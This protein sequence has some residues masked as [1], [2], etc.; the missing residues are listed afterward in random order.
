MKL[1]R[2][3]S[4]NRPRF[5]KAAGILLI[6]IILLGTSWALTGY[7]LQKNLVTTYQKLNSV[8]VKDRKGEE[9]F[10]LPNEKGDW[11]RFIDEVP[12]R[13]KELLLI[14]EDR[15]FY[16]HPGFNPVSI[17]KYGLSHLGLGRRMASSTI[18]QQ[19][20]KILLY[21]ELDR[22]VKNKIIELV[23][24]VSLELYKTKEEIL[25]MYVNSISFGNQATGIGEASRLYFNLPPDLL[26]DGQILQLLVTINNPTNNH[27]AKL[28]N[29][30]K[31]IALGKW[32]NLNPDELVILDSLTIK[33]NMRHYSR[34][35][36]AFFEVSSLI[37]ETISDKELTIDLLLNERLRDIVKR[38]LDDLRW[39]N[40]RNAAV[41]VIK[42]PEN[43]LLALIGSPDPQSSRDGYK[44][45][46]VS[47]PRPIGSTI[48]PFIYLKAFEKGLRPYTLVD[49]REYKYMTAIGLPLYPKN[50]DWKYR[51]EVD[52]HYALSNSLN[53][54]AVK[55]LEYVGLEDF[56]SFLEKNLG[57]KPI[58]PWESYQLGIALGGLDMSLLDL[59]KYFTIFPNNGI[60]RELSTHS[61][62]INTPDK[63][64][65]QPQ[66]IELIN[67][68]LQDRQTGMEQ[69]GMKSLLN[70]FQNNYAL[71]TGTSRDYRDSWVIGYTTDFLVGVWVGNSDNSPMDEVSGQVGAGL[72][73]SEIMGVL[74]N[75]GYNHKTPFTYKH[76]RE[77]Y[78][79]NTI[80][81][82]LSD[83]AY[84]QT[85]NI[86]KEKDSTLILSP[87]QDDTFLLEKNTRIILRAKEEVNWFINGKM[88]GNGQELTYTPVES[89][90]LQIHAQTREG[91]EEKIIVQILN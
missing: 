44:I 81:Y 28:R 8:A 68:I 1:S 45:N 5:L 50:Y 60:L 63:L 25:K 73:W 3:S 30:E 21:N 52:L 42:L 36:P 89:G 88:L 61:S 74:L 34:F 9:V 86:L 90:Y 46:M 87:H 2:I 35:K 23:Y 53:V 71:K 59:C 65:I 24:A 64:V 76:I 69:F 31:A 80:N 75:S 85:L 70:L 22:S 62:S 38:N 84:T 29:K 40:A 10:L 56:Y 66:Y 20:A 39:K 18:T 78:E 51:G 82:G 67:K 72:I 26:S 47:E 13:L 83:D 6:G 19:L 91:F 33:E 77:F 32:L 49:D 48:K 16:Q 37:K 15:Y 11:A 58:Q 41:V 27:P 12:P 7:H 14:K 54:P 43:E 79:D 17:L 4:I 57:F 55:V